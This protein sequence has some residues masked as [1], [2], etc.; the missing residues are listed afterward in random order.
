MD[1]PLNEKIDVYS[2][3]NNIYALLTG[4]WPFYEITSDSKMQVRGVSCQ[5]HS[6]RVVSLFLGRR[7]V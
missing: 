4:L 3:G 1:H 5:L 6:E 2:F 7:S